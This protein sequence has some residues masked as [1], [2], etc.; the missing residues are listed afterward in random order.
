[1]H[2]CRIY[3]HLCISIQHF[4]YAKSQNSYKN[5]W[6]EAQLMLRSESAPFRVVLKVKS[7][8]T[9]YFCDIRRAGV[10]G[11]RFSSL[12]WTSSSHMCRYHYYSSHK[13]PR[14]HL[15]VFS[16]RNTLA[17]SKRGVG[18]AAGAAEFLLD[19]E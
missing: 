16:C 9:G 7:V 13:T 18:A 17:A 6:M 10:N 19:W 8:R 3:A 1:M 12:L 5:K 2:I 11:S 14:P 15:K 4:V